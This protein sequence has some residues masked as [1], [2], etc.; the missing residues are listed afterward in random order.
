MT[1]IILYYVVGPVHP[2]NLALI[3]Q[4][5]PDWTFRLVYDSHISW[6]NDT[7]M[8]KI[9]FEKVALTN[10]HIPEQLWANDVKAVIFST[11]QPPQLSAINL[12]QSALERNVP[13][14]AIEE[15]NQ[16]ALN[17]GR[18]NNYVLPVDY[19]LVASRCEQEGM[20]QHGLPERRVEVTGW[21]F[22]TGQS[23]K[24][25]ANQ[26]RKMKEYFGLNPDRPVAA[27]TLTTLN[28]VGESPAIRRRLLTLAAEDLPSEYQLVVKPHPMELLE[29]VMPFIQEYA[30]RAKAIEGVVPIS[31]LL[32]AT[33][34]LLNRGASQVCFEAL[35]QKIPVIVLETGGQT[36]F[37]GLVQ[38]VIADNPEDVNRIVNRLFSGNDAM[39]IYHP[40]MDGHMPYS[41]SEARQ[42]TCRRIS[43][44]V[45]DCSH[46]PDRAGQWLDL[47]LYQSWQHDRR[48]ALKMLARAENSQKPAQLLGQLIQYQT[49]RSD[50]TVLKQYFGHGFRS[51]VLRCLWIDQMYLHK[52]PPTEDDLE[53]MQGFPPRVHPVW[54]LRHMGR[55]ADLLL[56]SGKT[57]TAL[58]FAKRLDT[59]FPHEFGV[60]N[61]V[62]D[63]E[64]YHAGL[65]GR[66]KYHARRAVR[67]LRGVLGPVKRKLLG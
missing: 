28:N 17:Q 37:H 9:P 3:A 57:Q 15:S 22:Y 4:E 63:I 48:P 14:I 41:P 6:F 27:L 24:V 66:A 60:P 65:S 34:V 58:D 52:E 31:D 51:Y 25:S 19:V 54:F 46:D 26:S 45:A 42:L 35:F 20:L 33:D 50:L 47:A 32:E 53:W 39:D 16:I 64:L 8:A 49:T 61:L 55:W 10:H 23:G 5:M 7:A 30:P 56:H 36:P 1:G 12:L 2:R 18:V 11:L 40:F 59:E 13:T 21:A 62:T 29:T 38:D 43:E 44:I 67:R